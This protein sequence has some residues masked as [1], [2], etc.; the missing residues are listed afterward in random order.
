MIIKE[1]KPSF[2]ILN[3]ETKTLFQ[4]LCVRLLNILCS[5]SFF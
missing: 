5:M 4:N 3:S 1:L 2:K